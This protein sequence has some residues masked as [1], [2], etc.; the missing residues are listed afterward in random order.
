MDPPSHLYHRNQQ[1][2]NDWGTMDGGWEQQQAPAMDFGY[3]VRVG[4]M[5]II[6]ILSF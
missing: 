2:N 6:H 3:Q 5:L 1:P 4:S